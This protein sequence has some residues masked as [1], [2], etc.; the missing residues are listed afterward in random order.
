MLEPQT[1]INELEQAF[2]VVY[3]SVARVDKQMVNIQKV[4]E[5]PKEELEAFANTIYD[6]AS[7]VGLS[8]DEYGA[9]VERWVTAGKTLEESINLAQLSSMGAFVGN[10]DESAMVDYMSVPLN[11]FKDAGVQGEDI[12]NAMNEV[13][14]K[15]AI[16]MD[17]LGMAYQRASGWAS[18][19]A[20]EII[21]VNSP[22]EVPAELAEPDARDREEHTV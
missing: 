5:A 1:I 14:N 18:S 8:A 19:C 15:N 2:Q 11:A 6:T 21:P 7:T 10:I 13:A 22:N 20:P 9:S 4:T 12:L 3:E 16:E 17:D